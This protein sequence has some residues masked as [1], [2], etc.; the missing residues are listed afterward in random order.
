MT[1]RG[2][3]THSVKDDCLSLSPVMS[4]ALVKFNAQ[5]AWAFRPS[6]EVVWEFEMN[7]P[8]E[9]VMWRPDGLTVVI[10]GERGGVKLADIKTGR[11]EM[12]LDLP[13]RVH[14]SHWCCDTRGLS[15]KSSKNDPIRDILPILDG[16]SNEVDVVSTGSDLDFMVLATDAGLSLI[17]SQTF[18]IN[19]DVLMGCDVKCIYPNDSLMRQYIVVEKS[20]FNLELV[21]MSL[22][23]IDESTRE[24]TS[25][26]GRILEIL[27]ALEKTLDEIEK[28]H[29]PFI[30]YT[31]KI[32]QLLKEEQQE[33][34][35]QPIDDLYDLL[36]T[37]NLSEGTKKWITDYL[38]DRGIK[39]W[40]KLGQAYFE[41][42]KKSIF[43]TFISSLTHLITHLNRLGLYGLLDTP[44]EF[45]KECYKYIVE[46]N[47]FQFQFRQTMI[48][49][50][51]IL[52]EIAGDEPPK[53]DMIVKDIVKFLLFANSLTGEVAPVGPFIV[54]FQRMKGSLNAQL[55]KVKAEMKTK[56]EIVRRIPLG[57]MGDG[58]KMGIVDVNKLLV[59]IKRGDSLEYKLPLEDKASFIKTFE[60]LLDVRVLSGMGIVVVQPHSIRVFDEDFGEEVKVVPV[61]TEI[62]QFDVNLGKGGGKAL[63]LNADGKR[64]EWVGI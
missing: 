27:S 28:V 43:M 2:E 5:T 54:I 62:S 16:V 38:G 64:F 4:F 36:L 29:T 59:L 37:G 21:E 30:E 1:T 26:Y 34:E 12:E 45:L 22:S 23:F 40:I 52:K 63:V 6:G 7:Q 8:I 35:T 20:D 41:F 11:I 33:D 9:R 10:F 48:W 13:G 32:M 46:V 3:L 57:G 24:V 42:S 18:I 56:V 31:Y 44:N 17:F 55:E 53:N 47:E 60:D 61:E 39:R 15:T 51:C 58:V 50:G 49:L 25:M 19:L 14:Y